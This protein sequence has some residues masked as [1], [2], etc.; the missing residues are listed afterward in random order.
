MKEKNRFS[1]LLEHL[2]SMAN[3]KNYV[4]AKA[5]QYDESYISKWISGKSLPTEKNYESILSGISHCIVDSLNEDTTPVL[6]QEYQLT[7][8]TDLV[9]AIYDN[10]I[11]EYLYVRD[12]QNTTGSEVASRISYYPELT[13]DQ[14]IFKMKHPALRKVN[15]LHVYAVVDILNIDTNYQLLIAEL[16]TLNTGRGL[17]LPGVEFSLLID[18]ETMP[19]DSTYVAG[20][21][22][23]VLTNLSN[24][25]F[26]LYCGP[27]AQRKIVFALKDIYAISGMLVDKSHC[28]AV[29]TIEDSTLTS[30]LYQKIKLLC[31]K[32]SLL[33][34]KTSLPEMIRSFEYDQSLLSSGQRCLLGHLTEH[35]VPDDLYEELLDS[36]CET[37]TEIRRSVLEKVHTIAR[38]VLFSTPIKVLA[39]TSIFSNFTVTG[40]LDFYGTRIRLDADQRLRCLKYIES[41]LNSDPN[42]Q[43]RILSD[44]LLSDYQHIPHPT[45]FLS[46]SITY[47]R[48]KKNSP[49]YN[50]CIP[51]KIILNKIFAEFFEDIWTSSS[52]A[53]PSA[54]LIQYAIRAVE[55]IQSDD[56]ANLI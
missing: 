25:N 4:L 18:L 39:Y 3:V 32:E 36:Y 30:E 22:M 10:L 27:Q 40:E 41:L 20:F 48:L 34:R 55:I 56:S 35:F 44:G 11:L 46:D 8:T 42:F 52:S 49:D 51:N 28:L 23:N 54:S 19:D 37:H 21:L 33:I 47:L 50:I 53:Q 2:M 12:L 5:V 14:F 29:T 1:V 45:L 6:L 31:T 17:I 43:L 15:S 7:S 13:L 38:K 24:I 26:N 9:T 16:N